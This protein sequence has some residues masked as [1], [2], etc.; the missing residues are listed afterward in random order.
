MEREP[1][2]VLVGH[3]RPDA[4]MISSM[5]RRAAPQARIANVESLRELLANLPEA[6]LLLVN[7]VLDGD[8]NT[9]DGV[10]LMRSINPC[11]TWMLVSNFEDAQSRAMEAGALQGFGKSMLYD[12]S[13]LERVRQAV[14]EPPPA[15]PGDCG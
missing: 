11:S 2:I 12:S 5:V 7:R 1:L 15:R 6:C 4:G 14:K 13:T 9:A 8:F 10:D 3:C